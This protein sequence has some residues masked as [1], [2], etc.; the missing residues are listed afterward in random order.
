MSVLLLK[1]VTEYILQS[2][3]FCVDLSMT[4]GHKNKPI[5]TAVITPHA[6]LEALWQTWFHEMLE[7]KRTHITDIG[8]S[9]DDDKY[10]F[11]CFS[12]KVCNKE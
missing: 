12:V 5:D 2:P 7:F 3:E 8:G 4:N 9:G 1:N 6:Q 10:F 11:V